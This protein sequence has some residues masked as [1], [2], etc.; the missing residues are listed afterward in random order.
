M[1]KPEPVAAISHS[2][3]HRGQVQNRVL[4]LASSI[5]SAVGAHTSSMAASPISWVYSGTD[6]ISS[7]VSFPSDSN[8]GQESRKGKQKT[9]L[10][11][12]KNNPTK[13]G[14]VPRGVWENNPVVKYL[15]ESR[16][17]ESQPCVTSRLAE[18]Q[19][20]NSQRLAV[21]GHKLN[22]VATPIVCSVPDMVSWLDQINTDPSNWDRVI[23]LSVL[24]IPPW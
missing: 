6:I 13:H 16:C 7:N 23:D 10:S 21:D 8:R 14:S 17:L 20:N 3:S 11:P 24:F 2:T 22:Q 12:Y 9:L 19:D 5:M 1:Q 15:V 4:T 18:A